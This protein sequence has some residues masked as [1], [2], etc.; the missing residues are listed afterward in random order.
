MNMPPNGNHQ[1]FHANSSTERLLP[2]EDASNRGEGEDG[3]ENER[4][5]SSDSEREP[6]L[7][8]QGVIIEVNEV[9]DD[10]NP[11]A[12]SF[13]EGP[14]LSLCLNTV[15]M[16]CCEDVAGGAGRHLGVFSSTLLMLASPAYLI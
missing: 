15:L 1:Y 4:P 3:G 6:F 7:R 11:G 10:V 8:E 12:L 14:S 2:T 13:D 5:K 9:E 16:L